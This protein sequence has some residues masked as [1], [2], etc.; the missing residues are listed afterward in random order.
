[1]PVCLLVSSPELL[2]VFRLNTVVQSTQEYNFGASLS[3][4]TLSFRAAHTGLCIKDG[5]A[6][7]TKIVGLCDV[8]RKAI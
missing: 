1:V 8:K 4:I 7:E 3:I 6:C 2:E 5:S